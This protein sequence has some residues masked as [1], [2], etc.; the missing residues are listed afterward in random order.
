MGKDTGFLEYNR[1]NNRDV[2]PEE[3]IKNFEEFHTPLDSEKRRQQ[4]ARC[5]NC[6]VPFCQSAMNLSGMV[7]GCPLN[8]L[9]PEWND[10]V[11]KAHDE[12]AFARL[13]KTSNFPEFTGRVCPALCE[14]ACMCGQ[15]GDAVT[16]HDNELFLVETAYA[17]GYIKPF[18][19]SIRSGKKVAVIGSGPS[20]LAV[21]DELNHRG[22]EVEVF[23][24]EDE[25][26]GLL[27][28]GIPNMKLDKSVIK[29][30]RKLMEKEGV[31]FHT[32]TDVGKD[33]KSAELLPGFDAVVFCCG[34]KKA[35][36]LAVADPEKVKGVYNAV[37]F[38]TSTT[39][40]LV[41]GGGKT[42]ASLQAQGGYI[43]AKD[44]NVVIVGGGD[45]GNDCIGT[46][47]RHGAKSVTA[48]EM[49]PKPPVERT[50]NNPWPE[51]PKTLK[52]DYGHEE[53]IHVF[54]S[55]P[56]VFETTVKGITTDKKGNLKQIETVK[57]TF[58]DGKLT[59]VP[60]S[61]K[62]LKCDILLI[63]AGFIGCE[64]YTAD[65]FSLKRSQ[66]GTVLT[67]EDGYHIQG[68]KLFAAGDMHRGQSLVVWAI[69]EGRA[70]AKEVDEY[71]MGYTN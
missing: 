8:N 34:A 32:G 55:D 23:E 16:V 65:E 20:G 47:I 13:H 70:C 7:V 41:K 54:G 19:P 51:W 50:A 45:T 62:N 10:E 36:P 68:T 56:R 40:A 6:G 58:K 5:M 24:R 1:T 37:D 39:K 21:A 29:R 11:Y 69:A 42:V 28:Y 48:L 18:I 38:L 49:M 2:P 22:H 9:I 64:D 66:R 3:R 15:N 30:R 4:A 14:K 57:V 43:D 53:A 63:A 35:R 25:I 52:T 67:A 46:V 26:G 61:E 17:K 59:E 44:K 71:L 33:V 27:M 60:G 31:V 12:H